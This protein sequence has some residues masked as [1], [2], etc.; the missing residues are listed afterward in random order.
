[1][2]HG[3]EIIFFFKYP[4]VSMW[5]WERD[6]ERKRKRKCYFLNESD[7]TTMVRLHPCCLLPWYADF[8]WLLIDSYSLLSASSQPAASS[9]SGAKPATTSLPAV[10]ITINPI[11]QRYA[12]SACIILFIK[13]T[14]SIV[15]PFGDAIHNLER[16]NSISV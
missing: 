14:D 15:W 4:P 16:T 5:E 10:Q 6:R 13:F 1:M 8:N 11:I 7:S 2:Q 12:I 3:C 9:Q